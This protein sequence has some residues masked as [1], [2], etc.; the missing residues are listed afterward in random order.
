MIE[1]Y[2]NFN[3]Q[4]EEAAL[5]YALAFSAPEPYLF[6]FADMPQEDQQQS[7]PGMENRLIH[8]NVKT[9]AG[10]IMLSDNLPGQ[11]VTP[12]SAN[13]ISVAD[14]DHDRLRQVFLALSQGGEVLMPL[15][16]TFFSPLYGQLRDKFGF[17]WMFLA[18]WD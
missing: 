18:Q 5:F 14:Q 16:K 2:L 11:E 4:A 6:R 9:F 7:P 10:D 8:G 12:T 17:Y 15:A 3:G 1:V 13:W